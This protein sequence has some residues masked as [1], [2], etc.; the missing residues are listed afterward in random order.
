MRK[1]EMAEI[2]FFSKLATAAKLQIWAAQDSNYIA[3]YVLDLKF[4]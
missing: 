4:S 1:R 2:W 3:E